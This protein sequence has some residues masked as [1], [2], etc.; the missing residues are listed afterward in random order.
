M[1]KIICLPEALLPKRLAN[2]TKYFSIYSNPNRKGV[3]FF[4]LSVRK[5][6]RGAGFCPP[7]NVWDF[8]T[9]A[10]AVT[11]A[12]KSL[13]RATA[14]DAWT[15]EI[16]LT[17]HLCDPDVWELVKPQLQQTLRFLTGDFW[18]LTFKDGGVKP[19]KITKKQ[20]KSFDFNC[21]CLLSGGVDSLVGAID[22]VAEQHKPIFVSQTLTN[23]AETQRSYAEEIGSE[24]SHIQW[25]H[26]VRM[27]D[28][29][30]EGSTRG[31]SIIFF[32]FAALAASAIQS[33]LNSPVKIYV[34]ENGFISLNIP[35]NPGRIGSLST[36]TT[37]PV[38][39]E[40]IQAIWKDVGI[41]FE[42]ATPYIFKTKGEVL[43]GCKNQNLLNK[44]VYRSVS[45][46]RYRVYRRR[47]C[48][49]CVPCMARRAA[50]LKM[51]IPDNTTGGYYFNDLA[52]P[53]KLNEPN[54][55]IAMA[56]ACLTIKQLGLEYLLAG[57]LAFAPPDKRENYA[58]VVSRGFAELEAL[59]RDHKAI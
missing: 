8:N 22:L 13:S 18:H 53:G 43:V 14:A 19:P 59:L 21:V 25:S 20:K 32:A 52:K 40:G 56:N 12:D 28:K 15:R 42:L 4:G 47:H 51:G 55:V 23:E 44:L 7:Q 1:R 37:H 38:Y 9:I 29:E 24:G 58:Q 49:R 5:N 57:S 36:K 39:L 3:G 17:I 31:R 45:C 16:D 48:G 54:D 26:S 27:P 6:I 10:W 50:F 46:G 2:D 35:L 41:N 30:R 34:P 33:E 11:A